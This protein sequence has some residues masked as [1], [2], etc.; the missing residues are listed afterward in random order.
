M[1]KKGFTVNPRVNHAFPAADFSPIW[2]ANR[3]SDTRRNIPRL[4]LLARIIKM[5]F[6]TKLMVF[7]SISGSNRCV[8]SSKSVYRE[9]L[10]GYMFNLNQ[11][12]SS[13]HSEIQKFYNI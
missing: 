6:S 7:F 3:Q 10:K 8:E 13:F 2:V 1:V 12:P 9:M 5:N 11:H 4:A